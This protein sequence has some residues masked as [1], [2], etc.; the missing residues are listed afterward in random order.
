MGIVLTIE[1][2]ER[3]R[4][5]LVVA[6][7]R[8]LLKSLLPAE[9]TLVGGETI[10]SVRSFGRT[11]RTPSSSEEFLPDLQGECDGNKL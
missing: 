1:Y 2:T 11:T 9:R 5:Y 3:H 7:I 8:R 10:C 4:Y 6:G